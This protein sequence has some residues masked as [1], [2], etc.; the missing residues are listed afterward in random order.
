MSCFNFLEAK[1]HFLAQ[2]TLGS[3]LLE[4]ALVR[5]QARVKLVAT[6]QFVRQPQHNCH[7]VMISLTFTSIDEKQW[8]NLQKFM[9]AEDKNAIKDQYQST[10][11]ENTN[12]QYKQYWIFALIEWIISCVSYVSAELHLMPIRELKV[13]SLPPLATAKSLEVLPT[14]APS[15]A[16]PR[17]ARC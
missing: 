15:K 10:S 16:T 7:H 11:R 5:R 17:Q 3:L 12:K 2:W 8:E 14:T 13:F 4:M 6:K 1:S 9:L